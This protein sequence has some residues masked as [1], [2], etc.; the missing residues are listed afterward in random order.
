MP[1]QA[2]DRASE[3]SAW[4]KLTLGAWTG[5]GKLQQNFLKQEW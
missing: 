5:E 4:E 2:G 1:E 3:A